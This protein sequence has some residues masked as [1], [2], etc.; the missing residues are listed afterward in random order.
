MSVRRRNQV[1]LHCHIA[2]VGFPSAHVEQE[3]SRLLPD[4]ALNAFWAPQKELYHPTCRN[5]QVL[6][7][8]EGVPRGVWPWGATSCCPAWL[9]PDCFLTNICVYK[10]QHPS[11][12][13]TQTPQNLQPCV[14]QGQHSFIKQ[15]P[16]WRF[17]NSLPWE[18]GDVLTLPQTSL[19]PPS[20]SL[21]LY[22]LEWITVFNQN[23]V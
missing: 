1:I 6:E 2:S 22:K 12:W 9:P 15:F 5:P 21:F 17:Y 14:S 11:V 13:W 19:F 8:W 23:N 4:L 7:G 3:S 16:A 18:C 10:H 20:I